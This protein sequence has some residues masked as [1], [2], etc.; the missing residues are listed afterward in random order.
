MRVDLGMQRHSK[1]GKSRV[2]AMLRRATAM[3]STT[4]TISGRKKDKG[5]AKPVTLPNIKFR[6]SA[7]EC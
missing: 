6:D 1:G 7:T 3:A 2:K 4:H 5:G